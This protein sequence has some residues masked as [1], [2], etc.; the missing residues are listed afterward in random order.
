MPTFVCGGGGGDGGVV[1]M[2]MVATVPTSEHLRYM[3]NE[4]MVVGDR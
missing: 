1:D 2:P 3:E 4:F